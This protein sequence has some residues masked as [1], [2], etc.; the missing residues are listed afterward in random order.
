[1]RTMFGGTIIKTFVLT[2]LLCGSA[3]LFAAQQS[4]ASTTILDTTNGDSCCSGGVYYELSVFGGEPYI[5]LAFSSASAATITDINAY[6]IGEDSLQLGIASDS[7]GHPGAFLFQE[8]VALSGTQISLSSLNWSIAAGTPYWLLASVADDA[9]T[10]ANWQQGTSNNDWSPF[11]IPEGTDGH[12]SALNS[13]APE[14]LIIGNNVTPLPA[15]L[16]LFASGLGALG[17]FAC[18]KKRKVKAAA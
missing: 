7:G 13:Q 14:A 11:V 5:A 9:N 8:T 17:L 16:P 12:W 1:M 6:I 2:L 4:H 3:S 10:E 15:A 18:R